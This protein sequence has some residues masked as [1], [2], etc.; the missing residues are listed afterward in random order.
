MMRNTLLVIKHE[1]LSMLG[2]RSFWTTTFLLPALIMLLNLGT[3][4]A[5]E[6]IFESM[7]A[8]IAQQVGTQ[9]IGYVDK[10]DLIMQVPDEVKD[11]LR[12]FEDEDAALAALEAGDIALYNVIPEDFIESGQVI[13][14]DDTISFSSERQFAPLERAINFNLIGDSQLAA[15]VHN[16]AANVEMK[17]LAPSDETETAQEEDK[18]LANAV[19]YAA[20]MIFFFV[21]SMSSGF[22]LRS[23]SQEKENRTAEVLLLSLR[24]WEL[25]LGKLIGLG[26]MGLLQVMIWI[27]G[28]LLLLNNRMGFIKALGTFQLPPMFLVWA[29]LYFLAGYLLYGSA[30]GAIGALAPNMRET[31]SFTFIVMLPLMLPLWFNSA[32]IQTPQGGLA[33]GLSLFPLTSPLAMMTRL[34]SGDVPLWQLLV[35]LS[36]LAATTYALVLLAA[37]F[38][39]ADTLLSG[40]ELNWRRLVREFKKA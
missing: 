26:A 11:A 33:V 29:L 34:A 25:M 6:T 4:F 12:A 19:S 24:P 15:V 3:Q 40:A 37:R 16:P 28:G 32:L 2:K 20:M 27:G 5:T 7:E 13:V 17:A 1:I 38:F 8:E 21:F 22:M 23:V 14:V 36:A 18:T 9:V 30:M 35:S 31:G 39:R 10:A